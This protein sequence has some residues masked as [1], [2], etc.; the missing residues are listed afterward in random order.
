MGLEP[1]RCHGRSEGRLEDRV[2]GFNKDDY[3]SMIKRGLFFKK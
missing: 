1:I 2:M 3:Y